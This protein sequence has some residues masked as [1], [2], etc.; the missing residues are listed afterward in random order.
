[1]KNLVHLPLRKGVKVREKKGSNNKIA[2]KDCPEKTSSFRQSGVLRSG[3]PV[4]RWAH[5]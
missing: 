1:M 2:Q 5:R 3:V 4:Y